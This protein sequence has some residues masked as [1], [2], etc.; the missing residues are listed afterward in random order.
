MAAKRRQQANVTSDTMPDADAKQGFEQRSGD[1]ILPTTGL[2]LAALSLVTTRGLGGGGS[3]RR[4]SSRDVPSVTPEEFS[5]THYKADG[6]Q[7]AGSESR[8]D[9]VKVSALN[10]V[11]L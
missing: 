5:K 4:L 9:G 11:P 6:K 8:A 10:I 3:R 7:K 2:H 1:V